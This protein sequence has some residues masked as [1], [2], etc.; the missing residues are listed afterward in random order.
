MTIYSDKLV[1]ELIQCL[2]E[3]NGVEITPNEA[4]EALENM[5]GLY[6][7]FARKNDLTSIENP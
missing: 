5:A 6:L 7:A 4:Q 1:E 2:K 3:E